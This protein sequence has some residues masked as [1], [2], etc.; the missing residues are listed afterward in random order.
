M[1]SGLTWSDLA[2]IAARGIAALV[3]S[4]RSFR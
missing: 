3:L 4:I 2:I 1:G